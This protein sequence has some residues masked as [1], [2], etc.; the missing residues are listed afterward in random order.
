MMEY[1]TVESEL[2]SKTTSTGNSTREQEFGLY[3]KM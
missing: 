2:T 1:Y 3:I